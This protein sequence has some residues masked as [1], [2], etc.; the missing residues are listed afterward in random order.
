MSLALQKHQ[1]YEQPE[2]TSEPRL[3]NFP[4]HWVAFFSYL[5]LLERQKVDSV[6]RCS[7]G[8]HFLHSFICWVGSAVN[9]CSILFSRLFAIAIGF[10]VMTAFPVWVMW[11]LI[12]RLRELPP[13]V[14][15]GEGGVWE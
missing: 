2:F 9:I 13:M 15:W 14:L 6:G 11:R 12:H 7:L 5:F 3:M 10:E 4:T 1:C 8:C